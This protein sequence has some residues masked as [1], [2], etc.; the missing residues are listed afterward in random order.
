VTT[1]TIPWTPLEPGQLTAM[2]I[3]A[4][5]TTLFVLI[6]AGGID[7]SL[8]LDGKTPLGLIAGPTALVLLYYVF[9]ATRRRYRRWGYSRTEHELHV[10]H[11]VFVHTETSVA[12]HRVQHIDIEQ[13]PVERY[14]GVWQL[15]LN[16]AGTHNS[17]IRLPGL[18][19]ATAESLRDEIRLHVRAD[20]E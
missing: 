16:T 19:R 13:G 7:L 4:A 17:K 1:P 6:F 11:G 18:S 2:Q 3:N 5:L 9:V 20:R 8:Y 15:V 14:C 10:A 12:F